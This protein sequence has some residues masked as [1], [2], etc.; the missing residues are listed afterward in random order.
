MPSLVNELILLV[1][2]SSLASVVGISELTRISQNITGETY[3]PL[4]IYITA[5]VI[6]FVINWGAVDRRPAGREKAADR[7]GARHGTCSFRPIRDPPMLYGFG[8]TILCWLAGSI[9]G[10][11]VG[12]ILACLNRWGPRVVGWLIYVYV[13]IIRGTPFMIQLFI[14]YYGGPYIGLM[15]T[16]LQ[17]GITSFIIYG[18]PYFAEIF[19]SGFN[20][21]PKGQIEAARCVGL[22]ESR[23][24]V[25]D[26]PAADAGADH[27]A[28]DQFL[29]HPDQGNRHPFG[30]HGARTAV[31]DPDHGGGNLHI[32]G[33]IPRPVA[34]LLDHGAGNRLDRQQGRTARNAPPETGLR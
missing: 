28:A 24:L 9:G 30:G 15:L 7:I 10:V 6:Y 21:I 12:F 29:H 4:E 20:A 31:P 26:H 13:E 14:L 25:A 16:P 3:R 34:V 32:R 5:A 8:I 22:S 2:V 23:I 19:R 1:K 11:I 27:C 17:A 18:S 33:A